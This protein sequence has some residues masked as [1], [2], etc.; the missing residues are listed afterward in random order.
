MKHLYSIVFV[1]VALTCSHLVTAQIIPNVTN[2]KIE[3]VVYFDGS[4]VWMSTLGVQENAFN[5]ISIYPNPFTNSILVD[6]KDGIIR[7][8]KLVDL[9]GRVLSEMSTV[10]SGMVKWINWNRSLPELIC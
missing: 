2:F 5:N 9:N 4:T 1:L 8:M 3:H 10:N 7:S 6:N